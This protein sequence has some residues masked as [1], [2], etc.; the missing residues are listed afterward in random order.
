M[1]KGDPVG[2]RRKVLEYLHAKGPRTVGA[3]ALGV[4]LPRQ[5]AY[6]YLHDLKNAGLAEITQDKAPGVRAATVW[7]PVGELPPALPSKSTASPQKRVCS[8]TF[9]GLLGLDWDK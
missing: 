7:A 4:G 1:K 6:W 5:T 8:C 9:L 2:G 3:L